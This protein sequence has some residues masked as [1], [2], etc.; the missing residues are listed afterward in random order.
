MRSKYRPATSTLW[1]RIGMAASTAPGSTMREIIGRH[2]RQQLTWLGLLAS[3]LLLPVAIPGMATTVGAFCVLVAASLLLARPLPLP[4]WLSRRKLPESLGQAIQRVMHQL[5]VRLARISK[6]RFLRLSRP[7]YRY[8]NG[9]MLALA[10]G[11]MMVP[12]PIVSFDNIVPAAAVMMLAWGMRVR[13]GAMLIMGY[14][15]TILAWIYVAAL[16]WA[17]AEILSWLYRLFF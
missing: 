5:A 17:G 3:P 13:D 1:I 2:P 15:T 9:A 8:I 11:S 6:P 10:G 14:I 4:D 7:G 12:V 16:W